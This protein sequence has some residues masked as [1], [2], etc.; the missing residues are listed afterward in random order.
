MA[1]SSHR[2]VVVGPRVAI[3]WWSDRKNVVQGGSERQTGV[4][5]LPLPGLGQS[6]AVVCS[7]P[8]AVV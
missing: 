3:T 1:A 2:I 4:V 6:V 5:A 7:F 8:V